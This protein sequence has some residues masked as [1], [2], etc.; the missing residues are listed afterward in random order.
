MAR[1]KPHVVVV[2][3]VSR[4]TINLQL[5]STG[6]FVATCYDVMYVIIIYTVF[7]GKEMRQI[8]AFEA[9]FL[10][11]VPIREIEDVGDMVDFE[12]H[13]NFHIQLNM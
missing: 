8:I 1:F 5:F 3:A 7:D 4:G 10:K 6:H 2:Y 12:E 13:D 11:S 9:P